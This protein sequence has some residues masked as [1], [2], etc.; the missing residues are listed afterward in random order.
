MKK[1]LL[2]ATAVVTLASPVLAQNTAAGGHGHADQG[3]HGGRM[4]D[5]AGAHAELL[6]AERTIT[7]HLYDESGKPIP[8]TGY[9]ASML[10]GTGQAREV[11]Q[12]S[13]R[14]DNT[15]AGDAKSALGRGASMTM[16]I[17]NPKGRSGQARF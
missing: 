5:V 15:L 16:Q 9:S 11:V 12:L 10:V 17:K 6:V 13:P 14:A 2:A 8:A 1:L 3:P 7:V 4:Q